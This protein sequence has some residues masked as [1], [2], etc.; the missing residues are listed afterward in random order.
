MNISLIGYGK[1]GKTIE[2]IAIKRG[3]QIVGKID[4]DTTGAERNNIYKAAD[5]GIE[6]SHPDAAYDNIHEALS[7]DLPVVSGTTGWLSRLSEI[8]ALIDTKKGAFFYASNYSVGVNL[9]YAMNER[10]AQLMN[11]YPS[12]DVSIKEVHHIHKKDEPSGTAI[13]TSEGITAHLVRKDNWTLSKSPADHEIPITAVREGEVYGIHEV[14][15][16]SAIDTIQLYHE[17][18][19]RDGFALG[20][21]LAAE[22]LQGK[23]GM[24]GMKE[25]LGL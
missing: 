9:F 20:A 21:V 14:T 11:P 16:K 23:Q 13:S 5:V 25:M 1:M 2:G 24:F 15:Y 19:T 3:H 17:A 10:L 12:Y 4:V 18:H 7:A 6:F 22:Y 8:Q